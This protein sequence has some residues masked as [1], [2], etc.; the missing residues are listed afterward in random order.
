MIYIKKEREGGFSSSS[1]L[2]L[3][4]WPRVY[5]HYLCVRHSLVVRLRWTMS[6]KATTAAASKLPSTHVAGK[7]TQVCKGK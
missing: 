3:Q 6:D 5:E 1:P 4:P 7:N 2:L